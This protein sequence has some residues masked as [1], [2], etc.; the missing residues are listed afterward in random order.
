MRT[1]TQ[2]LRQPTVRTNVAPAPP[3]AATPPRQADGDRPSAYAPV[4]AQKPGEV[5][6]WK[7]PS[8]WD[9]MKD[10]GLRMVEAGVQAI[11]AEVAYFF[12]RRRFGS[13]YHQ[14]TS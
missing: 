9:I 12:T 10:L 11:A 4:A 14:G 8:F 2:T 5:R 6:K 1:T 7:R 3:P 13:K